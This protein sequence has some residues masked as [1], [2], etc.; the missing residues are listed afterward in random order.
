M[1]TTVQGLRDFRGHIRHWMTHSGA[2]LVVMVERDPSAFQLQTEWRAAGIDITII[3]SKADQQERTASLLTATYSFAK[4]RRL[5]TEWIIISDDNTFFPS[6]PRLLSRLAVYDHRV[7]FYIG[8]V[9][10]PTKDLFEIGVFAYGGGGMVFSMPLLEELQPHVGECIELESD[11]GPDM[12]IARCVYRYTRTR[13][14]IDWEMHQCDLL[15]DMDGMYES[16]FKPLTLHHW[17]D[18]AKLPADKVGLIS[19]ITG[20]ENLFQRWRSADGRWV[21]TNGFSIVE[22][23]GGIRP[24]MS[25][26]EFTWAGEMKQFEQ[27]LGAFREKLQKD[28]EKVSYRFVHAV[29]ETSAVHQYYAHYDGD[30]IDRVIELIWLKDGRPYRIHGMN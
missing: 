5:P 22:F 27:S 16:G 15:G 7:P 17:H 19:P 26:M 13:L 11:G 28:T 12:R 25:K 6:I 24:D 4:S 18:W 14:T 2:S 21:L 23:P 20:S 30:K 8:A 9:S 3:E 1:S 10:E 29:H